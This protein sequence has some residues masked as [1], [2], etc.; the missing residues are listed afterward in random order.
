MK[1]MN[2][3]K[4]RLLIR[5]VIKEESE[6]KNRFYQM[7]KNYIEADNGFSYWDLEDWGDTPELDES[8]FLDFAA[9][10]GIDSKDLSA[11]RVQFSHAIFDFLEKNEP[12]GIERYHRTTSRMSDDE[13]IIPSKDTWWR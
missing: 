13:S 7:A 12:E 2:E 6:E 4:L 11:A 10:M 5:N 1:T 9:D 8:D 3:R